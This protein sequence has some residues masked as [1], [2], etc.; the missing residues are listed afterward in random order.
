[1]VMTSDSAE[2]LPHVRAEA[3]LTQIRALRQAGD[4]EVGRRGLE[5]DSVHPAF[6]CSAENLLRY[7]AVRRRDI[8]SLQHDL[9]TL[10]LSSLGLLESHVVVSLDSVANRLADLALDN[11][12]A[13]EPSP[14]DFSRGTTLLGQHTEALLGAEARGR[15]TVPVMVTLP[16]EAACS[17]DL[18]ND[19]LDAGMAVARINCAHDDAE[20]WLEMARR[21]RAAATRRG[22]N[23]RIQADLAGPKSRTGPIQQAGRLL[24]LRPRRD[25][26]GRVTQVAKLWLAR[27]GSEIPSAYVGQ[28]QLVLA[29][30]ASPAEGYRWL[31]FEDA[32]GRVRLGEVIEQHEEGWLLG[33]DRTCYI[34]ENCPSFWLDAT[35]DRESMMPAGRLSGTPVVEEVIR[36]RPDD[37]LLLTRAVLP[38]QAALVEET[39]GRVI[40]P[41]RLHC[42]LE[43]AFVDARAGHRVWLDDGRIGGVILSNNGEVIR[44]R[45]THA[46]SSG[47]RI[48]AEK[49]IN[50]PDTDFS[51]SAMTAKDLADLSV[52]HSV[53]DIIALSFVRGPEDVH[54]LQAT[55]H[56][57]SGAGGEVPG[58]VL[59]IE[60]RQAFERLPDLLLSGMRNPRFGVMVARG[61]LA[62]ELGFE[63]LAEVQEEILW[64]CEAA[65]VPVIWATQILESLAK[66]GSPS[67]PEVTDAAMS[68][69]AECVMLNKGPHIVEALR[70]LVGVLN[71]MEGHLDKRM[72][73]LRRL[74]IAG[75]AAASG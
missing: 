8:R 13:P 19:L 66:S 49:G 7:L 9:A 48:R 29:E 21:V 52:L 10:G 39:T 22:H 20:A 54:A 45:I 42:S 64:L 53:V 68:V 63:R 24:K 69:R 41:A 23:C 75:S 4:E 17:D 3:L 72:A 26:R 11:P 43:A 14:S 60:N 55:L 73:V 5:L 32:R 2:L 56:R 47:S 51:I 18:I 71:R 44:L 28:P 40:E 38:G 65:H 46:V 58:I 16:S 70:F 1:M 30:M 27:P 12:D 57:L 50:F 31:M 34:E 6:R 62:V 25:F 33:F 37:E 15:R 61:D 59:K 36:L 67:R 35:S 74:S